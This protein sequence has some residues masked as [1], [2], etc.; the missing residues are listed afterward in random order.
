MKLQVL[1]LLAVVLGACQNAVYYYESDKLS[2]TLEQKPDVAEPVSFNLGFKQRVVAV[3]PPKKAPPLNELDAPEDAL[4]VISRFHFDYKDG[5]GLANPT[6]VQSALITGRAASLLETAQAQAAYQALAAE[7]EAVRSTAFDSI[8]SG[9][10]TLKELDSKSFPQAQAWLDGAETSAR[11]ALATLHD[12]TRRIR[13]PDAK[14]TP[15]EWTDSAIKA[16]DLA[17]IPEGMAWTKFAVYRDEL[18]RTVESFAGWAKEESVDLSTAPKP[19]V[20]GATQADKDRYALANEGHK[21][22]QALQELDAKLAGAPG[23]VSLMN[24]LNEFLK[25]GN[26]PRKE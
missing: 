5:T 21:Q 26:L 6:L 2:L 19:L 14:G 8:N 13:T 7:D 22:L 4:S 12:F 3:V 25:T 10:S 11:R 9:V 1:A 20:D 17:S 23:V 24:A 16:P 18:R 15:K